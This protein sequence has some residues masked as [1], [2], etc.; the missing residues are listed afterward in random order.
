MPMGAGAGHEAASLTSSGNMFGLMQRAVAMEALS[1][2]AEEL[3]RL[4]PVFKAVLSQAV[5][6]DAG[7]ATPPCATLPPLSLPRSVH[8]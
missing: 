8:L 5:R 2:V 4:R 7:A 3:K 6:V 1:C